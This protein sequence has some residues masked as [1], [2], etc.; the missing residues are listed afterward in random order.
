AGGTLGEWGLQTQWS[1]TIVSGALQQGMAE[2]GRERYRYTS[3]FASTLGQAL[4]TTDVPDLPVP[5]ERPAEEPVMVAMSTDPDDADARRRDFE[6]YLAKVQGKDPDQ[7]ALAMSVA[8]SEAWM[9]WPADPPPRGRVAP[10]AG[11]GLFAMV[12]PWMERELPSPWSSGSGFDAPQSRNADDVAGLP[13]LEEAPLRLGSNERYRGAIVKYA[14]AFEMAPETLAA[15]ISAEAATL[16][17]QRLLDAR[18]EL[19]ADSEDFIGPLNKRQR[20]QWNEMK[21]ELAR[22]WDPRSASPTTTAR[23][24]AQFVEHTWVGEALMEDGHLNEQARVLGLIDANNKVVDKPGLLQ[25]RQDPELAIAAAA[26][27]GSRN[28]KALR[29]AKVDGMPLLPEVLTDEQE[30]KLM[31]LAHHEG[32]NGAKRLLRGDLSDTQAMQLLSRN[33]PNAARRQTLLDG[34]AGSAAKAY[35]AWLNGYID[36]KIRLERFR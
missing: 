17:G 5:L 34:H 9:P 33:V 14:H 32:L 28:L 4:G 23:G 20:I 18:D 15:L 26:A 30:A 36:Q 19:V 10:S 2:D 3:L 12:G 11:D 31:Y 7:P 27:Y 25:L 24:L 1:G 35:T 22:Q 13:G 16:K 6:R 29:A 8:E 21:N